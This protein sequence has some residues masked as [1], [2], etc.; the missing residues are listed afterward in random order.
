MSAPRRA[1]FALDCSAR[2]AHL[3]RVLSR[4]RCSFA[5]ARSSRCA[6]R[7]SSGSAPAVSRH[8]RFPVPCQVHAARIPPS[9][10]A[11]RTAVPAAPARSSTAPEST[12]ST[13]ASPCTLRKAGKRSER[14]C[15]LPLPA[16]I[17]RIARPRL[18]SPAVHSCSA[19]WR[20]PPQPRAVT[21]PR[22]ACG[23]TR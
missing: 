21:A 6:T 8:G 13:S 11:R 10:A 18:G 15:R 2:D 17:L 22:R 14:R 1:P 19:A 16:K 20:D 23:S 12:P 4:A 7:S 9:P 5:A 3:D